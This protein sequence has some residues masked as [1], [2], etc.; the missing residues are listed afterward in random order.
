MISDD[1]MY[2]LVSLNMHPARSLGSQ[3]R[4]LESES[5][6]QGNVSFEH[7]TTSNYIP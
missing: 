2:L 6:C 1:L 7:L 5:K 3:W 4:L